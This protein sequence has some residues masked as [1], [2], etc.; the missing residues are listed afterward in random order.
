MG[1]L[2]TLLYGGISVCQVHSILRAEYYGLSLLYKFAF[3]F[4][5][6]C[7]VDA[8]NVQVI[9]FN[10]RVAATFRKTLLTTPHTV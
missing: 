3:L 9:A 10:Y 7:D 6:S 1:W 8:E 4:N 5:N 2:V